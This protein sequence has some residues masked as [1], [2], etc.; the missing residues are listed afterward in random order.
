MPQ[1]ERD[2]LTGVEI[3]CA[4]YLFLFVIACAFSFGGFVSN[5]WRVCLVGTLLGRVF[6]IRLKHVANIK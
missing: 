4:W 6:Y 3:V 2:P 1:T 5:N